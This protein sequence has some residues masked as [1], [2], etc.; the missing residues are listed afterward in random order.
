[1]MMTFDELPYVIISL[2]NVHFFLMLS[3]LIQLVLIDS[4]LLDQYE[5]FGAVAV[6]DDDYY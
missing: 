6:V 5:V 2:K 1:M 4:L 3:Y